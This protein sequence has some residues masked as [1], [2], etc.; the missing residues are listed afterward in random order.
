MPFSICRC[1]TFWANN[2]DTS[3]KLVSGAKTAFL[4][5]LF[6][7][8]PPCFTPDFCSF[9]CD[10]VIHKVHVLGEKK[11]QASSFELKG[12]VR[13]ILSRFSLNTV[14]QFAQINSFGRLSIQHL[15]FLTLLSLFILL[16]YERKWTKKSPQE[17]RRET[18][19]LIAVAELGRTRRGKGLSIVDLNRLGLT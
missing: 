5:C 18:C 14:H 8:C 4:S 12:M 10:E 19:G 2:F 1:Q 3:D 9:S 15:S 7:L 6:V 11:S 13:L 17:K 16:M